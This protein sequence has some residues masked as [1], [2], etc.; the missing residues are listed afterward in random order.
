M[1][2]EELRVSP[3]TPRTSRHNCFPSNTSVLILYTTGSE[4]FPTRPSRPQLF[5]RSSAV[6]S[7]RRFAPGLALVGEGD[8]MLGAGRHLRSVHR[9]LFGRL[10]YVQVKIPKNDVATAFGGDHDSSEEK[11]MLKNKQ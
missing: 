2:R 11:N 3:K 7:G 9:S 4:G 1:L 8:R 6:P 10:C 5:P